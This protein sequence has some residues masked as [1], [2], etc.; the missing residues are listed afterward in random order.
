VASHPTLEDALAAHPDVDRVEGVLFSHLE[1]R[2]S[3]QQIRVGFRCF[4]SDDAA[5]LR[6]F[7]AGDPS[8][9]SG[10]APALDDAGAP[11]VSLVR[12]DIAH[13]DDGA[14]VAAQP[15]RYV[16]YRPEPTAPARILTGGDALAWADTLRALDQQP[17]E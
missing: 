10:L 6:A 11:A 15:V 1:H 4:A 12:L 2:L 17:A 3:G 14:I 13:V 7:E 16:D 8:A 9:L 5:L